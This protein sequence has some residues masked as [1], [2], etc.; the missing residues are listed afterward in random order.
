MARFQLSNNIAKIKSNFKGVGQEC[1][2]AH[3][4]PTLAAHQRGAHFHGLEQQPHRR[5]QENQAHRRPWDERAHGLAAVSRLPPDHRSPVSEPAKPSSRNPI[6]ITSTMLAGRPVR[7]QRGSPR[8]GHPRLDKRALGHRNDG[9]ES[10]QKMKSVVGQPHAEAHGH[11]AVG[12]SHHQREQAHAGCPPKPRVHQAASPSSTTGSRTR[13]N[14]K[15]MPSTGASWLT[16]SILPS[17]LSTA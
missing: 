11:E 7:V 9:V 13:K 10:G 12:V 15:M 6:S 17:Q 5:D 14:A 2:T 4:H 3:S 8:T 1:P 16:C